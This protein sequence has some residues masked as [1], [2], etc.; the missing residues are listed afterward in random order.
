MRLKKN[1]MAL[2]LMTLILIGTVIT[3][4]YYGV[5]NSQNLQ[6]KTDA[7]K[8]LSESE[9]KLQEKQA[10]ND[11]LLKRIS[12]LTDENE[13]LVTTRNDLEL[14]LKN[15][16]EMVERG[17]AQSDQST[18]ERIARKNMLDL[19]RRNQEQELFAEQIRE[20]LNV[21][22]NESALE[23][24]TKLVNGEQVVIGARGQIAKT[25]G[26]DKKGAEK[27]VGQNAVDDA[28]QLVAVTP[29]PVKAES[30]KPNAD[31]GA[32]AP[33]P[34]SVDELKQKIAELSKMVTKRERLLRE[35]GELIERLKQNK[36]SA[37]IQT[38]KPSL[39][40]TSS[41][42]GDVTFN[43]GFRSGDD[44]TAYRAI[45][46]AVED[47]AASSN[48]IIIPAADTAPGIEAFEGI[49]QPYTETVILP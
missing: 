2:G 48:V 14:S 41:N 27:K 37:R 10:G 16:Q 30:Q 29:P 9:N 12:Q 17:A 19:Q 39:D 49:I 42:A 4:A 8:T 23:L 24:F 35:Q 21:T 47:D 44:V 46:S 13:Q 26:T 22:T 28:P 31:N 1:E 20:M 25:D 36:T 5:K 3:S 11:Q 18:A 40:D 6:A 33:E 45:S 43:Q 34:E 15:Y 38:A 7:E 32:P